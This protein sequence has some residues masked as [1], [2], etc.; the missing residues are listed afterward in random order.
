MIDKRLDIDTNLRWP[1]NSVE[2][3]SL[4]VSTPKAL[5]VL[6]QNIRDAYQQWEDG[7]LTELDLL[8]LLEL[9]LNEAAIAYLSGKYKFGDE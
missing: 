5:E 1:T 6:E 9:K 2:F 7:L 3:R 4:G 8:N